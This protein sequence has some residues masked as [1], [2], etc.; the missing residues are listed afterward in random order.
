MSCETGDGV[1]L[2]KDNAPVRREKQIHPCKAGTLQ[3]PVDQLGGRLNFCFLLLGNSGGH[4]YAGGDQAVLLRVV[5]K[6]AGELDLV[7][8]SH[9]QNLIAQYGAAHLKAGHGLLNDHL[10]IVGQGGGDGFGQ[11]AGLLHLGDAKEEPARA[12]LTNRG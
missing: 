4:V 12:G 8:M 3:R 1:Y 6:A 2:V 7:H 11:H 10:A 5:E 9:R